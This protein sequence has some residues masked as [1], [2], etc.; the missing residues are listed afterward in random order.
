MASTIIGEEK[1]AH[2][3]LLAVIPELAK[4]AAAKVGA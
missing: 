4:T 3:K 1:S 2:D